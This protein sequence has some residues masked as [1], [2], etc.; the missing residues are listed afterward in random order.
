VPRATSPD[1][2]GQGL[3]TQVLRGTVRPPVTDVRGGSL[4]LVSWCALAEMGGRIVESLSSTERTREDPAVGW[5]GWTIGPGRGLLASP[6]SRRLWKAGVPHKAVCLADRVVGGYWVY[7][8]DEKQP[9]PR[10]AHEAPDPACECGVHAFRRPVFDPL[11]FQVFGSVALWGRTLGEKRVRAAWAYPRKLW[12]LADGGGDGAVHA[13]RLRARLRRAYGVPVKV[14]SFTFTD[15]L[16][17][18]ELRRRWRPGGITDLARLARRARRS[19]DQ[20]CTK[21]AMDAVSAEARKRD[22]SA[23]HVPRWSSPRVPDAFFMHSTESRRY[24]RGVEGRQGRQVLRVGSTR[25]APGHYYGHQTVVMDTRTG[26]IVESFNGCA[27]PR[28]RGHFADPAACDAQTVTIEHISERLKLETWMQV[29]LWHET[30][31]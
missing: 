27:G 9:P 25:G 24:M 28:H 19:L 26:G 18:R 8:M 23:L 14:R 6:G 30:A 20:G 21:E 22:L 17:A 13:S 29:L 4:L 10:P 16:L 12:V 5:R 1:V 2:R 31:R 11:A 7:V 15:D 3:E